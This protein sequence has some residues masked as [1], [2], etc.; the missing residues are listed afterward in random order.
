MNAPHPSTSIAA[1]ANV[2]G[3]VLFAVGKV[4]QL[5]RYGLRDMLGRCNSRC[6]SARTICGH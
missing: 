6:F 4:L 1:N 5:P 2:T 3:M